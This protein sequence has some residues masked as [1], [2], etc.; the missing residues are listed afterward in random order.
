MIEALERD[1]V[2][3]A[4]AGG[5]AVA[6]WGSPR[7][8]TDIDLLVCRKDVGRALAVAKRL[9]FDIIANPM[10]FSD[11]A[12]LCRATKFEAGDQLT[13][14]L[15]LTDEEHPYW[16]TRERHPFGTGFLT[17]VSR[18]TLIHMKASAARPQ[19]LADIAKLRDLD[20]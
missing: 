11:G 2:E 5:L 10:K 3:Y 12:E 18:D 6:I 17:V 8:T 1:Q 20:R 16:T 7:A 13:V 4:V 14:D 19:D 9:G 15:L